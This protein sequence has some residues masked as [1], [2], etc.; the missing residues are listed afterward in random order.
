MNPT[1]CLAK[2]LIEQAIPGSLLEFRSQQA[3]GEHDFDFLLPSGSSGALEVTIAAD[4]KAIEL[5]VAIMD[6]KKGGDVFDASQCE[7]AWWLWVPSGTDV[8]RV[9]REA[10]QHLRQLEQLGIVEFSCENSDQNSATEY[11]YET[12]KIDRGGIWHGP[13]GT[14]LIKPA[15]EALSVSGLHLNAAIER[16]ANKLDNRAKLGKVRSDDRHLVVYIDGSETSAWI[17]MTE[18]TPPATAPT[19]PPEITHVWAIAHSGRHQGFRVF[20]VANG[21]Q[22]VD[23]GIFPGTPEEF[24]MLQ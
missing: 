9:R 8:R 18:D 7:R 10:A 6:P 2:H 17:V 21:Q 16:E 14:V 20:H 24:C 22:W 19:L 12:L 15:G 23:R 4:Q 13:A 1:E 11:L 3:S 5:S